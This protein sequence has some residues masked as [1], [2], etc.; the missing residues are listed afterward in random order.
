M[1]EVDLFSKFK[2]PQPEPMSLDVSVL[3]AEP[4]AELGLIM[5]H[6]LEKSGF[7]KVRRERDG[8][9]ALQALQKQPASV[10]FASAD[11]P[12]CSGLDLLKELREDPNLQRGAFILI[13][14][15]LNKAE[16]MLAVESGVNELLVKPF[17]AGDISPKIR[18]AYSTYNNPKNPERLYEFA[19]QLLKAKNLNGAKMVYQA[20]GDANANA[21]RPHVGLARCYLQENNFE[22]ALEETTTAIKKNES[23]VHAYSVRAEI[24]LSMDKQDEAIVDLQKAVDL[25]PLN[26]ARL[27]NCCEVLL[28]K[29]LTK[30]CAQ[31]LNK[32]ISAGL[33]H[34][35]ITERLGYCYFLEK[36]YPNAL[37][38]LKEAVR[39]D[40]ENVK[41][42]NSLAICH[43]D[44]KNYDES[45]SIY[46]RI[47]KKEPENY[48]VLYNK[49]LILT[50]KNA[51]QDAVKLLT[52]VL[53]I[54][55]DF[56]KASA[57]LN[58]LEKS[59]G[60]T[61]SASAQ[62]SEPSGA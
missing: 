14:P 24:Y 10:V 29:N 49:A 36:D 48:Q 41:F 34:P 16:V 20:L 3:V 42:L 27:E 57:K 25:S 38:F 56:E 30:Q 37:R 46:N 28:K 53:Q 32:A 8:L 44:S 2:L 35:Y 39:I 50:Y 31:I 6:F 1:S 5:V 9:S 43:R 7:S 58:E 62:A 33:E 54:K 60:S 13:T 55:P 59:S 22:K 15:P 23:F 47:I 26:L 12:S 45:I 11:L 61:A 17:T 51:N 19:K 21:A 40:P 4:S 52:R 18:T